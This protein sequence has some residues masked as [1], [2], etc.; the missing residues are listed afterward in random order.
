MT[1]CNGEL[2]IDKKYPVKNANRPPIEIWIVDPKPE[3]VPASFGFTDT[4]PAAAFGKVNP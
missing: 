2:D 4:I 1:N 3:A